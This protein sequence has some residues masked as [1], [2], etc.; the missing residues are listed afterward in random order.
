MPRMTRSL[1]VVLLPLL[2]VVTPACSKKKGDKPAEKPAAGGAGAGAGAGGTGGK[3]ATP[4]TSAAGGDVAPTGPVVTECPKS[5]A[6]DE[7]V[8]RVISKDCGTVVVTG[9]YYV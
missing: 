8:Q 5:L 1:T 4:A 2:M 7:E 3:P 6:G 9:D